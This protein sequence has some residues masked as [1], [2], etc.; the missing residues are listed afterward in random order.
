M[1]ASATTSLNGGIGKTPISSLAAPATIRSMS[2]DGNDVVRYTA[3]GFG[4][5]VI[6]N[7]D[8]T[9]DTA[10]TQDLID[11]SA[12]G[13]TAANIGTTAASRIQLTD[14]EDGATDDTL[15]TLRDAG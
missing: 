1:A 9:G 3:N 15:L 6:N 10:A 4:A 8:A 7:F 5:D 12:L 2:I 13:L 14:V 11:L